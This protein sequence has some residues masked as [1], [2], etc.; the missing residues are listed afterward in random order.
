MGNMLYEFLQHLETQ[1]KNHSI[2]VWGAQG[3][4]KD[5]ISES[6]IKKKETSSDNAA[7][8]VA[9]WKKQV[10]AG[11]GDRLR[12]FDC[13]GLGMRFLLDNKLEKNDMNADSMMARCTR[14][15][16][17]QLKTGD[18]VFLLDAKKRAHHIGY[19]ADANLNVIEAKGR[20]YGVVKSSLKN[21]E[22]YGRPPYFL[23][24]SGGANRRLLRL[25]TP[26]MTGADVKQA[27]TALAAKGYA[28]VKA[29]GVFG[30]VTDK[31]VRVFQ[32]SA[33]LAV[34]GVVGPKTRAALGIA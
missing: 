18:F 32:A 22:A 30:L 4:G 24:E 14:I 8:A 11:Y 25:T 16:K 31:A 7:R 2:Y 6:W 17:D 23:D 26:Y 1:V 29:D 13:S 19:V 12:A 21:W 10:A 9:F 28:Y 33:K 5:V 27:Q 15:T 3:E 20:D 34:D